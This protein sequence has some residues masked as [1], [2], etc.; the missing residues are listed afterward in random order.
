MKVRAVGIDI[1]KS[2]FHL[3]A[4]D[5]S[6]EIINRKRF[7]RAQLVHFTANLKTDVIGM[8]ACFGAHFLARVLIAQ[9]HCVRLM[10]AEY[11]RAYV[12][13]NKNDFIDAAAIAEAVQRPTMRFVAVKTEEQLD[14]Q[15]LHRV[16]ERWME[17]RTAIINQIRALLIERGIPLRVGAEYLRKHLPSVLEDAENE[18]T[19]RARGLLL[20]LRSELGAPGRKNR[21]RYGSTSAVIFVRGKL[22]TTE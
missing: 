3:V 1:A 16:R 7:T 22:W 12:K 20:E 9:G 17:R 5:E 15:A 19:G 21:R 4:L 10:P 18:L 13:S 8:E 11:V 14:L 6:G 2:V